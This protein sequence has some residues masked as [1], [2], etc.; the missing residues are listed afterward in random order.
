MSCAKYSKLSL[1]LSYSSY[2]HTNISIPQSHFL[3][4][5]CFT[6]SRQHKFYQSLPS[7]CFYEKCLAFL[8][9]YHNVSD[10]LPRT[11]HFKEAEG[12]SSFLSNTFHGTSHGTLHS[13]HLCFY[14]IGSKDKEIT[15]RA[16]FCLLTAKPVSFQKRSQI[17]FC[18]TYLL[19]TCI[20]VSIPSSKYPNV[21]CLHI[22]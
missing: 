11:F 6:G 21:A 18:L 20:R 17:Y 15:D 2:I 13:K 14:Y 7:P 9:A 3:L 16:N 4:I 5:L 19:A 8:K 1:F 22:K 12:V 10:G